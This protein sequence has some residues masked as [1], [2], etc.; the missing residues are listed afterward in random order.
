MYNQFGCS[1][2]ICLKYNKVHHQTN[3]TKKTDYESGIWFPVKKKCN[4]IKI[5]VEQIENSTGIFY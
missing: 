3:K 1:F 2:F 5:P 4:I